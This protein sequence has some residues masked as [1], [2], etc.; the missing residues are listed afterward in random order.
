MVNKNILKSLI[1]LTICSGL[2]N[3]SNNKQNQSFYIKPEAGLAKRFVSYAGG[4]ANTNITVSAS[5]EIYYYIN[6][7]DYHYVEISRHYLIDDSLITGYYTDYSQKS[8]VESWYYME[9]QSDNG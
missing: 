6:I 1:L 3:C 8:Y 7:I 4:K 5:S 9:W 2:V